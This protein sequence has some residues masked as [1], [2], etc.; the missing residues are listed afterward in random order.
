MP[1]T[2]QNKKV[3][4]LL[5]V[6]RSVQ[7]TLL[8]RYTSP[9]WIR[10]EMNKLN[11]YPQSGHCFPELVEKQEGRVIAEMRAV[12]WRD[13]YA[14]INARFH[15][16]LGEP[17]RD[18]I[19]ILFEARMQ[20]DPVRGLGLRV[21]DIDPGFSLGEL[22]KERLATINRLR[23][24]GVFSNNQHLQLPMLPKRVAI[25]SADS[26]KGYS[27]FMKVITGNEWQY[28][29]FHMLFPA[30][31]QGEKA[32][33][34]IIYQLNR[35]RKV[36]HHF[37]VVAII[38]GGGGDVGLTCYN[39]YE[40]AKTIATYP[41]PVLTG[42]GHSTNETVSEM[43]AFKN[44]ITPTE[45][46][47]FLIQQFHNFSVPLHEAES[48]VSS[49]AQRLLRENRTE[50]FNQA[51]YLRSVTKNLLL[52][53]KNAI[54]FA[55]RSLVQDTRK[56]FITSANEVS[57]LSR[58]ITRATANTL[59]SEQRTVTELAGRIRTGTQRLFQ[60]ESN[61]LK[62]L[63]RMVDVMSP[64]HTLKRGFSITT[65]NGKVVSNID[66]VQKGD[67]IKTTLADGSLTSTITFKESNS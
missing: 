66:A 5:E 40:L 67:E 47:D 49:G 17:L 6:M 41:I 37:D 38:R 24:E 19:T 39:T 2:I 35:I 4:S 44:A 53:N 65:I 23:S 26:S 30:F 28:G 1:E 33:G 25:I 18:G 7:K 32:V 48:R 57:A 54:S 22:E 42:I 8:E 52:G 3:F 64:M 21:T 62:N 36:L 13:D 50:L 31:L 45:L 27:D 10:A 29:F 58:Q 16:L 55:A 46:A 61:N 56:T 11:F 51:R 59:N 14:R 43:V 34:S 12:L 63:E 60:Q 20:F 9:F 15:E